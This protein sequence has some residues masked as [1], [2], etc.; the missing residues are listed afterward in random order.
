MSQQDNDT[1]DP[2]RFAID[3]PDPVVT[4]HPTRKHEKF[5]RAPL[6]WLQCAIGLPGKAVLVVGIR[7]WFES[8]CRKTRT[9]V[10]NLSRLNIPR[11]T[12]HRALVALEQAG[13]VEVEHRDGRP[14]LITL[15]DA[16]TPQAEK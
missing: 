14:P 7:L 5:V 3:E 12:A 16:P 13:L 9:V 8:G 4:L 1:F 2:M 6:A 15:L 11:M 10:L